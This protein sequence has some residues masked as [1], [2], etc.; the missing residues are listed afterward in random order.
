MFGGDCWQRELDPNAPMQVLS[1]QILTL[2]KKRLRTI[3]KVR[4]V[5]AFFMGDRYGRLSYHL[6][7]ASQHAKGLEKMKEAMRSVDKSGS[8][9][10]SDA[11]VGQPML[12]FNFDDPAPFVTKMRRSLAGQWRGYQQFH[13]FALNET[14]F[15]NPKKMLEHPPSTDAGKRGVAGHRRI[16][17]HRPVLA[18]PRPDGFGAGHARGPPPAT[19]RGFL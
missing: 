9:S 18:L 12:P 1:S 10:F 15:L 13:D 7:F 17:R 4:Y 19:P 3:P 14:P 6:V 16:H 8:Y 5:F 11:I 2:Y